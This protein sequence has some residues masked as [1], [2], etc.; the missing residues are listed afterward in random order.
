MEEAKSIELRAGGFSKGKRHG[1]GWGLCRGQWY[2][3][4]WDVQEG[5]GGHAPLRTEPHQKQLW[6]YPVAP[7]DHWKG[8]TG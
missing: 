5:G 8:T 1:W 3:M 2:V 4:A 6:W 7:T